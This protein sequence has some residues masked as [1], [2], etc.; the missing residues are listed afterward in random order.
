MAIIAGIITS[1][2][3]DAIRNRKR[4][5]AEFNEVAEIRNKYNIFK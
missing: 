2:V 5:V 1:I 4:V 3:I